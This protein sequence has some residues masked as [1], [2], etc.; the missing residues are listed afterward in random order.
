MTKSRKPYRP[1]DSG[2]IIGNYKMQKYIGHGSFGDIYSCIDVRDSSI[3]AIKIENKSNSK[4]FLSKE[5]KILQKIQGHKYFPVFKEYGETDDYRYLVL[6]LLG[7]SLVQI[8]RIC[9][10]FVFSTS[11]SIRLGIEM[12]KCI[13]EFHKFGLIHRDIKPSNFLIRPSRSFPISLIDYG[14]SRPFIDDNGEL[15]PPRNHPGFVG[16]V[17]FA[18]IH[19]HNDEELGRC[20]DLYSW[21]IVLLK[22]HTG[23]IPW[24]NSNDKKK[25][26]EAKLACNMPSFCV[27]LPP[28]YLK[29]YRI[30]TGYKREDVPNYQMIYQLL[31]QAMLFCNCSFYDRYDWER[32]SKHTF[33]SVTDLSFQIPKEDKPQIPECLPQSLIDQLV[34]EPESSSESESSEEN[35]TIDTE[36]IIK[37][38]GGCKCLLL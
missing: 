25:V 26:L 12:L 36:Q 10:D 16:T 37:I 15:I 23:K 38:E 30:I 35:K 24:P 6:E 29:I 20:D 8:R 33:L 17:P 7:P 11:T 9:E 21:F 5:A 13:E 19:A 2:S 28:Q 31:A 3:W 4:T 32:L 18:S 14:L 34:A 27:G 22:I 1:V